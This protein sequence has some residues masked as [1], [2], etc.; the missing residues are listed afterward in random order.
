MASSLKLPKTRKQWTTL[1]IFI[2][3]I[4]LTYFGLSQK[5]INQLTAPLE[6][7]K[8][9]YY[10]VIEVYDGDTLAVDMSGTTEKVRMIGV[11]TPET[12]HP[13]KPVQCFGE[14]AHEYTKSLIGRDPVRLEMDPTNSNRDRYNRLLR[15][16]YLPDGKLVNEEIVKA[17]YGFAYIAFPFEKMEAFKALQ[18]TAE[19]EERGLWNECGIKTDGV[20][21]STDTAN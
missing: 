15:Y 1:L 4:V 20:Y 11:D 18:K 7:L 16:V 17:G 2:L 3:G 9:G 6:K 5:D 13:S 14:K 12:H 10:K 21:Q 8:P 19:L